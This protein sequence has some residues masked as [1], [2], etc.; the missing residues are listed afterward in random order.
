MIPGSGGAPADDA[1]A[2]PFG[3]RG[4]LPPV[5]V[6][7]PSSDNQAE[8]LLPFRAFDAESLVPAP[9]PT[10]CARARVPARADDSRRGRTR[11]RGISRDGRRIHRADAG[12]RDAFGRRDRP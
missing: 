11:L 12:H 6:T 2:A 10:A 5:S 9:S 3:P 4:L 7:R 1:T 8:S